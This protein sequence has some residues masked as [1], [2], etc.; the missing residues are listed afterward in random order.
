MDFDITDH[1][2][3][4][5]DKIGKKDKVLAQIFYKKMKEIVSKD[6][7]SINTYKNLRSPLNQFKRIHLTDN[8]IL[9]FTTQGSK[10]IFIDIKHWD[11]LFG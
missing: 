10:I 7:N 6:K 8:Y 2:Q 11:N 4:K 3:K 1:L 5:L 9:I